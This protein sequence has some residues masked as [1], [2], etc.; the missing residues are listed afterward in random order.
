MQLKIMEAIQGIV[1]RIAP[2]ARLV[3]NPNIPDIT[4]NEEE[5]PFL[6]SGRL[7]SGE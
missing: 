6:L 4:F 2:A 1:L 7:Y 3:P 5:V